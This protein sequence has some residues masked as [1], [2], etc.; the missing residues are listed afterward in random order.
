MREMREEVNGVRD[1]GSLIS[2]DPS[3]WAASFLPARIRTSINRRHPSCLERYSELFSLIGLCAFVSLKR[4]KINARANDTQA[5]FP[6]HVPILS[7]ARDAR[8]SRLQC[9]HGLF[10]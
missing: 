3:F 7:H 5:T 1:N 6:C 2:S 10:V 8:C 4:L 9:R